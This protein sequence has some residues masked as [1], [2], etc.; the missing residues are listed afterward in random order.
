MDW[1]VT[2]GFRILIWGSKIY[3]NLEAPLDFQNGAF[4]FNRSATFQQPLP[5]HVA[6][7][8][9]QAQFYV[10]GASNLGRAWVAAQRFQLDGIQ[11]FLVIFRE[12]FGIKRTKVPWILA[13]TPCLLRARVP[14]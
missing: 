1:S 5:A 4:N 3:L 9:R 11:R 7:T 13:R 2:Y 6:H 10:R 14:L 12:V 8:A